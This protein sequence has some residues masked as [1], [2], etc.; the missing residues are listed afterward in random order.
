M[1]RRLAASAFLVIA[2]A[3][4]T[5]P[6]SA[7]AQTAPLRKVTVAEFGDILLYLPLYIAQ[8]EGFLARQGLE[9]RTISTG[10]DDK[11]FAALISGDAEFGISDPTFAAIARSK[12]HGGKVVA[13][14]VNGAPLWG[15]AIDPAIP[16]ITDAKGLGGY[17]VGTYPAPTTAYTLQTSM[18]TAGGQKPRIRQAAFGALLPLLDSHQIDIALEIE[19]NVSTAVKNGARIVYSMTKFAPPLLF[20][21]VEITDE[22]AQKDPEL[23]QHFVAAINEA[24]MFA[25]AHPDKAVGDARHHFADTDPVV[26]HDAVMRMLD[27]NTLPSSTVISEDA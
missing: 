24:E 14:V 22:L 11:T 21:G 3:A 19:P 18:F 23:V 15:V 10:N 20:T 13:A 17:T 5:L 27:E 6:M 2:F 26:I 4:I 8:S 25:H 7:G 16:A 1:S 9:V 12:G